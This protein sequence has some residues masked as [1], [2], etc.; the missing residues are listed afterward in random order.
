MDSSEYSNIARLEDGHWWY[1][2]LRELVGAHVEEVAKGRQLSILDA[3]CGTGRTL[4]DH[5]EHRIV[6]L[7]HASEALLFARS[8]NRA[9]LRAGVCEMP[10]P[11]FSFDLVVSLDVLYHL[12]VHDDSLALRE[13]HRVIRLGGVLL[14]QLPAFESLRGGHDQTVHTRHRYRRAEV[15]AKLLDAGFEIRTLSY[16]N[17]VLFPVAAAMRLAGR[18][19]RSPSKGASDVRG[20]PATTNRWLTGFLRWEN[21]RLLRQRSLP[22]GLSI[23]AVAARV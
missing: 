18:L 3:G 20:L 4:A 14:L 6:G 19:V 1:V 23:F 9:V 8:R 15:E 22:W 21:R 10:F 17:F 12:D 13:M 11:D 16:R 7:D 2:G 5:I